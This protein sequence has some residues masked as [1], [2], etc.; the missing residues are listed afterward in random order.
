MGQQRNAIAISV[1]DKFDEARL[2]VDIIRENWLDDYLIT[3]CCNHHN[4]EQELGDLPIDAYIQGDPVPYN[5]SKPIANLTYRVVDTIRKSCR[6]AIS[7]KPRTVMHVHSDAWPLREDAFR[8]LI[9]EMYERGAYAAGRGLGFGFCRG[10]CPLGHL[11]DMFF[12]FDASFADSVD[13]FGIRPLGF[14][15][16]WQTVH[17]I[18]SAVV[19]VKVGLDRFYHYDDHTSL[20]LWPGKPKVM[21]YERAKPVI[22]DE[23][24]AF[25][26]VH[27]GSFPENYGKHIQ[28]IYLMQ[29]GLTKGRHIEAFLEKW[30]RKPAQVFAELDNLEADLDR[31]LRR[32]G[33]DPK[34][35]G[36][37][38]TAKIDFLNR[39]N[40]TTIVRNLMKRA[41]RGGILGAYRLIGKDPWWLGSRKNFWPES[42]VDF[43]NRYLDSS[44]FAM[45]SDDFWFTRRDP[46]TF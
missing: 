20:V 38:Y 21:P 27:R 6:S 36:Q 33:F 42:L 11:D 35:F 31:K 29:E 46:K 39:V 26:H 4:G 25:L 41:A 10:D 37:E 3:V 40:T 24:R 22:F 43:Y 2:L 14:L 32:L 18:L 30:Y 34:A 8:N 28:A 17:G 5:Q 12:L 45:A 7:L 13:L 9:E 1:Y 16:H 23:S 44:D 15:P 19:M